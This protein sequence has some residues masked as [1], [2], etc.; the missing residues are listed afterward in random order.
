MK[1]LEKSANWLK[2]SLKL[3]IRRK[4]MGDLPHR[5]GFVYKKTKQIP[6]KVDEVAQTEFIEFFTQLQTEKEEV[7]EVHYFMDT[8]HPWLE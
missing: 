8:V 3:N 7:D 5:I 1:R 4:G 6:M 2:R